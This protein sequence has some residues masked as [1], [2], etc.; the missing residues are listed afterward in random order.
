MQTDFLG[1]TVGK[2]SRYRKMQYMFTEYSK[3]FTTAF[4]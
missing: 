4:T 2:K 1:K 3:R